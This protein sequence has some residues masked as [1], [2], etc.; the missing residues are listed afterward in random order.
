MLTT[1]PPTGVLLG[2]A[3]VQHLTS[4]DHHNCV[5]LTTGEARCWGRSSD[6]Q[7]GYGTLENLG[8][9]AQDMITNLPL[10]DVA[11]AIAGGSHSCALSRS[12]EVTCW[13]RA[14]EGQLGYGN[15]NQIGHEAGSLADSGG[16]VSF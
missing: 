14:M 11:T 13:G 7:I 16:A 9:D 3:I 10:T 8:D 6:G 5:V 4:E 2:S 1:P 12:G 15:T